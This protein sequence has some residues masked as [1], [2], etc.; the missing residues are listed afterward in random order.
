MLKLAYRKSASQQPAGT[1]PLSAQRRWMAEANAITLD[2][3]PYT[4][5]TP[6]Q[7]A[8]LILSVQ[9]MGGTVKV[10]PHPPGPENRSQ[11]TQAEVQPAPRDGVIHQL[12]M[13]RSPRLDD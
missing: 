2:K 4:R 6:L 3:S 11:A 5:V 10:D 1:L 13:S 12:V 8:Q 7:D 9:R